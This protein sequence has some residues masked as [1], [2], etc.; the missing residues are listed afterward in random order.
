MQPLLSTESDATLD[1]LFLEKPDCGPHFTGKKS[2]RET[3]L[4]QQERWSQMLGIV[5]VLDQMSL[6]QV[7]TELT[8]S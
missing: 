8:F 5:I 6:A 2:G 4:S 3:S 7:N 1:S